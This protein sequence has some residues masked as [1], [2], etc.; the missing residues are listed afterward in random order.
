MLSSRWTTN[1]P[2]S[3]VRPTCVPAAQLRRDTRYVHH[4]NSIAILVAEEGK[5]AALDGIVVI[6]LFD[7]E[8]QVAPNSGIDLSFQLLQL[9]RLDGL[10]VSE[11][12]A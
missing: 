7:A 2:I 11:I 5:R 12:E 8:R 10:E 9:G 4:S 3:P 1:A 6:R